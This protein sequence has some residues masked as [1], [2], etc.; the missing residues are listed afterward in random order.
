M[1]QAFEIVGK[2]DQPSD[3]QKLLYAPLAQAFTYRQTQVYL[4]EYEGD[5]KALEAFVGQVLQD[6][7]TQDLRDGSS[8]AFSEAA[9]VLEY[10]MKAGALD[11]EKET[12]LN[13]F[14]GLK[15]PGFQITRLTLRTRLYVF[16]EHAS[17]EPLIRDVCNAAI[18][19][20][21]VRPAA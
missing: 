15:Q 7:I 19:T 16:G 1:T 2:F 20:W 4:V 12:I 8:A 10:G 3:C 18:H 14:R 9:F 5:T 13:Y 21:E 6:P 11:L 17:A